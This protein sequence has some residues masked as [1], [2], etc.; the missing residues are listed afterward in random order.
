MKHIIDAHAATLD[1]RLARL[2]YET[3]WDACLNRW[4]GV[5]GCIFLGA[6][7]ISAVTMMGARGG[8]GDWLV[9]TLAL[10]VL[11]GAPCLYF[12]LHERRQKLRYLAEMRR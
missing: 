11:A 1:E 7:A 5:A 12:G 8:F 3:S 2:A 9:C 4:A 6:A 10:T